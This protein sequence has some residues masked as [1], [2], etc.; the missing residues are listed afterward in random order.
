MSDFIT[1]SEKFDRSIF[2][3]IWKEIGQFKR[4]WGCS[5]HKGWHFDIHIFVH[6]MQKETR[7]LAGCGLKRCCLTSGSGHVGLELG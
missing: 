6:T 4:N 2:C 3:I 5:K 1:S 7:I